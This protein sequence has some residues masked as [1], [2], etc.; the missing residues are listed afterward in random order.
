MQARITA[1]MADPAKVGAPHAAPV[2]RLE[3]NIP[4]RILAILHPSM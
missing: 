4:S 2:T 1:D 3:P